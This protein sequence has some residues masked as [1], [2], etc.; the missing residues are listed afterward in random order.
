[1]LLSNLTSLR[2]NLGLSDEHIP[3]NVKAADNLLNRL[4]VW[5]LFSRNHEAKSCRDAANKRLRVGSI[6][7]PLDDELKSYLGTYIDKQ[8]NKRLAVLHCRGSDALDM[9]KVRYCL[10]IEGHFHRLE[11]AELQQFKL[12][13][14]LINPFQWENDD[15]RLAV[16]QVFDTSTLEDKGLP[17]T[18][19]TNAGEH[20]WAV[21]LRCSELIAALPQ[22]HTIVADIVR[23]SPQMQ[24]ASI[25]I[26]IITG[27]SPESGMT[28]WDLI[29]QRVQQR[30][31]RYFHGDLTY[32]P[33]YVESLPGMG[34]SMELDIREQQVWE[35]IEPAVQRLCHNGAKI[36]TLACNTTPYFS[37]HIRAICEKKGVEFISIADAVAQY[38]KDNEIREVS[39]VGLSYVLDFAKYSGFRLLKEVADV[40]PLS[41]KGQLRIHELAYQVKK[42]GASESGLQQLR[43]ILKQETTTKFV[44]I[45]LTELSI[46]LRS[47]KKPGRSNRVLIDALDVYATI[48]ADHYLG[49]AKPRELCEKVELYN[50]SSHR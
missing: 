20:T 24:S 18:M 22:K 9:G 39:L 23:P 13:Y 21:E 34:L 7:I 17:G 1:M 36:I 25:P 38:L 28:L 45:A 31:G 27:N 32:P 26:G 30:F 40:Y 19:M 11:Y 41:K 44:V 48:V 6:G 16:T 5:H 29:N 49:L 42:E 10:E 33:V 4:G 47:Q 2:D 37:Q 50:Q 14:G 12:D 8:G 15:E 35:V 43:D 46:L 3:S